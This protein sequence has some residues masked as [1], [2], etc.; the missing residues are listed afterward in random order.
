MKLQKILYYPGFQIE[1]ETWLK[2]AL[3][4]LDEI[5]T[6]VPEEAEYYFSDEY[7]LIINETNLLDKYPPK[8]SEAERATNKVIEIITKIIEN[9]I[10]KFGV[11]GE[12]NI[13]DFWRQE[14]IQNYE[15]YKS[16]FNY[17]FELFCEEMGFAHKSIHGIKVPSLIGTTYMGVL[18]HTIGS[19]NNMSIITDIEHQEQI[20]S[21]SDDFWNYNKDFEELKYIKKYISLQLPVNIKN[22]S[23][24]EIIDLRNKDD[25]QKKLKAFHYAIEQLNSLSNNNLASVSYNEI[26]ENIQFTSK[27]LGLDIFN[28]S[29]S[30]LVSGFGV[31]LGYTGGAER[32]E[33][34]KEGLGF[35][36]SAGTGWQLH[37]NINNNPTRLASQYLT[38]IQNIKKPLKKNWIPPIPIL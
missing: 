19:K 36:P 7:K 27:D 17:K 33:L 6:I 11:L 20:V 8:Y 35:I 26:S 25:F 2:F 13:V 16:K 1:D 21:L 31:W 38:D 3:L 5:N 28:F 37:K 32:L 4:Y 29:T 18:A 10:K 23:F 14:P 9:P 15:L 22:I 24:G 30:L 12:I 34:L